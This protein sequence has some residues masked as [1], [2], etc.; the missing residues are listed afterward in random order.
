MTVPD[1]FDLAAYTAHLEATPAKLNP[2][3]RD[4]HLDPAAGEYLPGMYDTL[5]LC[6]SGQC[7]R[8]VSGA[9]YCCTPCA[10]AWESTPRWDIRGEHSGMCDERHKQRSGG[11]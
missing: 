3:W 2:F 7:D 9:M 6:E 4:P 1:G 11:Q 5:H 10:L 8:R